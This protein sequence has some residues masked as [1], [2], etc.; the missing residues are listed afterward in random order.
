MVCGLVEPPVL[1]LP[2]KVTASHCYAHDTVRAV[3]D[4]RI[5]KSSND[6]TIPR[7]TWWDHRGTKEWVQYEFPT[8]QKLSAVSVYWFD[9]G[10][11]K[12]HC[13]VP[14]SW[15]LLYKE[16]GQ[17]KPVRGASE[18][19]VAKDKYNRVSFEPVTT[20][21]M[22]LEFTSQPNWA[23]GIQKWNLK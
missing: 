6:Q 7:F 21:A 14:K 9:D 19:G 2:L 16:G 1:P 5:P 12:R 13:R 8:P 22:R 15:Q 23:S 20:D 11:I 18:F 3:A 17:W 10:K 4:G